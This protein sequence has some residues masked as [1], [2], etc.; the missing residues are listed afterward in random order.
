MT[1]TG[2]HSWNAFLDNQGILVRRCYSAVTL[3]WYPVAMRLFVVGIVLAGS[4]FG[5]VH[6]THEKDRV[7]V[8]IDGRAFG[9]LYFGQDA[10]KPFFHPL[11]TP[12]GV[13]VTRSYPVEKAAEEEPVDHPHQKGLWI[14]VERLSGMDFWENDSSYTR[15]RMGKIVFK[16]VTKLEAA[17]N[18]GELRFRADW[19]N[20]EGVPVIGE[21][22]TMIFYAGKGSAHVLDVDLTLTARI[23]VSFEDHQDAV[24]GTRLSPAFDEKNGGIAI[25]A[26]G[27]RGE[28]EA[29]G[30]AS[31]YLY[32]QTRAGQA[33]VGVAILDHPENWNSP[34]RWH[35]RSFGFFTANP[36]ARRV[37]DAKAPPADKSLRAGE[38][39]RLRYRVLVYSGDL[40]MEAQWREYTR[41]V[42][43]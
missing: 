5:Q 31:R 1:P 14:G 42:R 38:A 17:G 39:L 11:T 40:D 36:F 12:S 2:T 18:Q 41:A 26:E 19:I 9:S 16:D 15:P 13:K 27:L 28:K 25:N 21:D 35:L 37:F 32:W 33:T 20:R 4:L 43:P 10:N 6:F 23:P 34:A 29:R 22:R 7:A 8:T 3:D 24:I 30:K